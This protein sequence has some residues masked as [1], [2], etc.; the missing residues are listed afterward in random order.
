MWSKPWRK[1]HICD[2]LVK[3]SVMIHKITDLCNWSFPG[4]IGTEFTSQLC[5][6]IAAVVQILANHTRDSIL[7]LTSDY[8]LANNYITILLPSCS[9][10]ARIQTDNLNNY[11]LKLFYFVGFQGNAAKW[12]DSQFTTTPHRTRA[13][14]EQMAMPF[15]HSSLVVYEHECVVHNDKYFFSIHITTK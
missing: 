13:R 1:Y 3:G 14:W 6:C 8:K 11:L 5:W 10:T 12:W 2:W 4:W 7:Q 9:A 15:L